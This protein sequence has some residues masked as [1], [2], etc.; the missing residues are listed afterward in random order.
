MKRNF[1]FLMTTAMAAALALAAPAFAH[2]GHDH[3]DEAPAA[4]SN[5]PSASLMAACFFR[6]RR[7]VRSVYAPS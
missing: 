7:N 4:S 2:D 6:N 1:R 5:G 3:G